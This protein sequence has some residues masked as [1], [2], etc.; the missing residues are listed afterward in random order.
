MWGQFP[1][2]VTALQKQS[3]P[4]LDALRT[5]LSTPVACIAVAC[6]AMLLAGLEHGY[7]PWRPFYVSYA[8]LCIA[9]PLFV[10]MTVCVGIA[11]LATRLTRVTTAPATV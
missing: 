2:E 3:S 5:G 4:S 7:A 9:V 1:D 8:A 6:A 11:C 10:G